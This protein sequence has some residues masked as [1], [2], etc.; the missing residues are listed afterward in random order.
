MEKIL[1]LHFS[2]SFLHIFEPDEGELTIRVA[3]CFVENPRKST[4]FQVPT[5]I[6]GE[7]PRLAH[8]GKD[9]VQYTTNTK[10]F[11]RFLT[12]VDLLGRHNSSC[13]VR[14][15]FLNNECFFD[16]D[17]RNRNRH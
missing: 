3:F 8:L 10:P 14:Q 15:L 13:V 16:Y 17:Q 5:S 2:C 12:A 6:S 7:K 9:Y 11:V 4:I 1:I